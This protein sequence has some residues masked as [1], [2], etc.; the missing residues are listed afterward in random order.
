MSA[1]TPFPFWRVTGSNL[2]RLRIDASD[3]V[4][5]TDQGMAFYLYAGDGPATGGANQT[6]QGGYAYFFG[7]SGKATTGG[8]AGSYGG[9][10]RVQAGDGAASAQYYSRGGNAYVYGGDA[11]NS[12]YSSY[13]GSVRVIAGRGGNSTSYNSQG[14]DAAVY[15][16]NAGTAPGGYYSDGGLLILRGGNGNT[17]GAGYANGGDVQINGGN[18]DYG[19]DVLI[20][21]GVGGSA[22]TSGRVQLQAAR[23]GYFYTGGDLTFASTGGGQLLTIRPRL[24][25]Q[26]VVSLPAAAAG[27]LGMRATVTDSNAASFTAGIGA[28]VAGG[29][30]TV[31]PVVSDGTNWRIG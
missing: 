21:G 7:G 3:A 27:N 24:P 14:G 2:G 15:G 1:N 19:G 23:S 9:H 4:V 5:A 29:G 18:G 28:V 26:T 16:G 17:G 31:V 30:A 12:D 20:A 25:G 10:A 6:S 13:G 22:P 8:N 11:G